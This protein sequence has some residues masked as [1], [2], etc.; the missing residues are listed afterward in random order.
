MTL[1]PMAIP[2]RALMRLESGQ[3]GASVCGESDNGLG[4]CGVNQCFG[5]VVKGGVDYGAGVTDAAHETTATGGW[6]H[7]ERICRDAGA[8]LCTVGQ[9]PIV[10]DGVRDLPNVVKDTTNRQE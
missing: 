2:E 7:A 4:G 1:L 6:S 10:V 8:R 9:L 5:G 3:I